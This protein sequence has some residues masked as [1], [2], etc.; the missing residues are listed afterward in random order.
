MEAFE[1]IV[2]E[3]PLV[4]SSLAFSSASLSLI[5]MV[6]LVMDRTP[7][8]WNWCR[9]RQTTSGVAATLAARSFKVK[10]RSMWGPENSDVGQAES[11]PVC[12]PPVGKPGCR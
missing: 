10:T 12:R 5:S 4:Q 8:S 6:A 1:P 9:S 3:C 11:G 7:S 2:K